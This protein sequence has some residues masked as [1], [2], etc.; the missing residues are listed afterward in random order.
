MSS[1]ASQIYKNI[2]AILINDGSD[3]NSYNIAKL[4]CEK[5]NRF[6][7]I[8]HANARVAAARDKGLKLAHGE[9]VIHI[10]ADDL[11][12]EKAME[13]LYQSMV[14]NNSDIAVGAY[15]KQSDKGDEFIKHYADDKYTFTRNILT[16][17]YHSSLCNKLTKMDHCKNIIFDEGINYME[18]K[19]F[20]A[21]ILRKDN[22]R[23]FIN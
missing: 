13:Y 19:L 2:E 11:I 22:I 23:I 7:L 17:Q 6:Q 9:Y 12:A 18:H 1:I 14:D 16:G 4:F 5:D 8:T 3:D 21:K 10:D 15:T 20:L